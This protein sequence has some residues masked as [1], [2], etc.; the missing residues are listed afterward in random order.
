MHTLHELITTISGGRAAHAFVI[1]GAPGHAR[2]EFINT[3]AAGLDCTYDA[4][5][6]RPC[7]RCPSCIQ[8]AAGTNMDIVRMSK[9]TGSS[10]TG[11]ETYRTSDASAFIERLSMGSYGRYLIGIID[12]ADTLSETIQNKLLKTLEEPSP[13]TLIILAAANR[14]NLLSTVLSRT[15][16]V[17]T[18]D[19]T[20]MADD[21]YAE[22]VSQ[23]EAV[24]G[25]AAMYADHTAPFCDIRAAL[26]KSIKSR[27]DALQL[28]NAAED[29]MR[30]RMLEAGS[31]AENASGYA[32]AIEL[33]NT[34]R[35]DVRRDMSYGKALRRLYLET[36]G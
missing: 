23:T 27:E 32:A 36:G 24:A 1:E 21:E 7:G 17:R 15:S 8:V 9:S 11:R 33:I 30:D 29:I 20:E 28:L 26:D 12:D 10:K 34:A 5:S 19:Y 3:L 35:M 13:D 2:D 14:D 18:I 4:P 6:G 31:R 16:I 25:I 22:G